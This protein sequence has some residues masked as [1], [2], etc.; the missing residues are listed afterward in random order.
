[1]FFSI[2]WSY[3]QLALRMNIGL[4]EDLKYAKILDS[5][6]GSRA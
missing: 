3:L 1:M 4:P 6:E 2:E 5:K